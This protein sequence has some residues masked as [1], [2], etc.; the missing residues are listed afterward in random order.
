MRQ[1]AGAAATVLILAVSPLA[2]QAA[3]TKKVNPVLYEQAQSSPLEDQ[4]S[5]PDYRST[6]TSVKPSVPG[7]SLTVLQFS[8]RL[9]LVNRTGKTVTVYG[10]QGEPYARVLA[11]GAVQL[12]EHSP[13]VYLNTTFYGNVT[14]PPS[15]NPAD[16]PKWTTFYR[17]GKFQWHDHR[18]HWTSPILPKQVTDKSKRTFIEGWTVPI[19]VGAQK[20]TIEGSLFWV[21]EESKGGSPAIFA[22]IAIAVGG[23]VAVLLVR[24]RRRRRPGGSP[25]ADAG[26]GG[27]TEPAREAW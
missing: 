24:L 21:P 16:P 1:L 13:A 27:S 19:A 5:N 17:S 8:D 18:I 14:V 23:L 22:L 6:I 9:A 2:A 12:N 20:G 26:T 25:G 7:L 10:Y 15:A 11:N 4:G 3:P